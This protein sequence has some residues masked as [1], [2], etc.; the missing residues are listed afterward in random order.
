MV[1]CHMQM[2]K[3]LVAFWNGFIAFY[4]Q[5]ENWRYSWNLKSGAMRG[6]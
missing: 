1:F 4:L 2:S 5:V 6:K 3:F